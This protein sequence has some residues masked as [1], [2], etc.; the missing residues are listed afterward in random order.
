MR[1]KGMRLLTGAVALAGTLAGLTIAA[2]PAAA[3]DIG[4]V[5]FQ[6]SSETHARV[7]N[8][9]SEAA[10]EPRSPAHVMAALSSVTS[11]PS[12]PSLP[13]A[14]QPTQPPPLTAAVCAL[15]W[16]YAPLAGSLWQDPIP[17]LFPPHVAAPVVP[18][19]ATSTRAPPPPRRSLH[20]AVTSSRSQGAKHSD[21]DWLLALRGRLR[22]CLGPIAVLGV[23]VGG[24]F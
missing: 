24:A 11:W 15:A 16:D 7:A 14:Q 20:L 4:V 13:C 17:R 21:D 19:R 8:A 1:G 9:A 18:R 6:F 2:T 10:K 3:F 23:G 22:G 5:G 12:T